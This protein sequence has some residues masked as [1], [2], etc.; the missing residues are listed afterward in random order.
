MM[1]RWLVVQTHP[2]AE[3]KAVQHLLRQGFETYLPQYLK[4]RRHAR[5]VE[6]VRAPLF[7]RYLF[8]GMDR[9]AL[10]WRSIRSTIGVSQLVTIGEEP[11]FVPEGIINGLKRREEGGFIEI[12]RRTFRGG[13]S[14]RIAEGAF[15]DCLG[16]F[17]E[18]RDEE[19]VCVLLVPARTQGARCHRRVGAG[20]GMMGTAVAVDR[21]WTATGRLSGGA[22]WGA[23]RAGRD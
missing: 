9:G 10:G 15:A 23:R 8:V 2:R 7:P 22:Q 5:R 18:V 20:A 16:L 21:V 14:V 6:T 1:G 3:E 12:G 19:R 11:A 13:D 17:E 4:R